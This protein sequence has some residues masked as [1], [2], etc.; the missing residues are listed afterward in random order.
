M[1]LR[2]AGTKSKQ[3]GEIEVKELEQ[4]RA[5]IKSRLDSLRNELAPLVTRVESLRE[6]IVNLED[7]FRDVLDQIREE[8]KKARKQK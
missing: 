8:E 3:Q 1:A 2:G 5:D 7:D 6:R 4:R